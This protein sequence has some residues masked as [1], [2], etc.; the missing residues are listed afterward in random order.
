MGPGPSSVISAL[1]GDLSEG[2]LINESQGLLEFGPNPLTA[3]VSVSGAPNASLMVQVGNGPLES[4]PA[5]IDS[6][7]VYGTIPSSVIGN[8]RLS[9]TL[10]AG[11]TISVYTSDGQT[12]L[13]SYTTDGT[14]SPTVISGTSGDVMNTGNV[15]F[16]QQP[17]YISYSPTGIGT[18]TFDV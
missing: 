15:P 13:Y 14:N 12:L 5:V 4:V 3:L 1:P 8:S 18:T 11:T 10:P 16:A 7:G 2:V 6:G 9:G 17:V